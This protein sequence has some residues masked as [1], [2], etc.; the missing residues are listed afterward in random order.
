MFTATGDM[1]RLRQ[2]FIDYHERLLYELWEDNVMYAEIRTS[3]G[4]LYEVDGTTIPITQTV[5]ILKD[6]VNNFKNTHPNFLGVKFIY[7]V[8]RRTTPEKLMN[9]INIFNSL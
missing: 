3:F 7:A 4:E 1:F 6:L 2:V 5:Q 9:K 8:N